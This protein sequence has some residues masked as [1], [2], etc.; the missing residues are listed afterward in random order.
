MKELGI[1]LIGCGRFGQ[2]LAR[3]VQT[4]DGARVVAVTD[5]N[6]EIAGVVAQE[7]GATC[8]PTLDALLAD[9]RVDSVIVAIPHS[10][11]EQ[12]VVATAKA[13]KH[14]FCEKPIAVTIESAYRM[15]EAAEHARVKLMVG[16]VVR[17]YP[18][19]RRVAEIVDEGAIG[20]VAAFNF[21][22]LYNI[23]RVNWWARS[24]TMGG[25]LHSPGVHDIDFMRTICG[26][27]RSVS[28]IQS[29]MRI[30]SDIDYS[31]C[32]FVLIEFASGAIGSLQSSVSNVVPCRRGNILGTK[33]SLMFEAQTGLIEFAT[34]SG[35][36]KNFDLSGADNDE[37]VRAELQSFVNW[38]TL[39]AKPVLTAWDGLRAVEIIDAA[40]RSIDHRR[41]IDL[42]LKSAKTNRQD[43]P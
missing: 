13:Q 35:T 19:F 15:I 37:G 33:G 9:S 31:D 7:L 12:A 18:L 27:A 1:G 26:E 10:Y 42:P 40:Y 8:H 21:A 34:F 28:A 39:D 36:H 24:E 25:L 38:V 17:L 16:Q 2:H 14:I 3:N 23:Q 32:V 29:A 6:L 4:I 41:P 43:P 5:R 22:G 30:Q 11:H 20:Q